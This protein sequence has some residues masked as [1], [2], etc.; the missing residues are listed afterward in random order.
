MTKMNVKD[1]KLNSLFSMSNRKSRNHLNILHCMLQVKRRITKSLYRHLTLTLV[2]YTRSS[3]KTNSANTVT[4][5]FSVGL[6]ATSENQSIVSV[7]LSSSLGLSIPTMTT[8]KM[9]NSEGVLLTMHSTSICSQLCPFTSKRPSM[10]ANEAS[11]CSITV[12]RNPLLLPRPSK[13]LIKI[14]YITRP[15]CSIPTPFTTRSTFSWTKRWGKSTV[16]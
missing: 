5:A 1:S 9:S 15:T 7:A 2:S 11:L 14:N 12:Q 16:G 10:K 8:K 6:L 3:K 4:E 13:K